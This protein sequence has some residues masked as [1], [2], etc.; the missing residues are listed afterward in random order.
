V[1]V[2]SD[3]QFNPQ[4]TV[5]A[6]LAVERPSLE[7]VGDALGNLSADFLGLFIADGAESG[8]LSPWA[9]FYLQPGLVFLA[10]TTRARLPGATSCQSGQ[11]YYLGKRYRRVSSH[12]PS[13]RPTIRT[14]EIRTSFCSTC[15]TACVC[16][17]LKLDKCLSWVRVTGTA[18]LW[19]GRDLINF[20]AMLSVLQ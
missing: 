7:I 9:T 19:I 8:E 4:I 10:V 2:L 17:L 14:H 13:L 6:N 5:R 11:E 18:F 16:E 3:R 15:F 1:D 20:V 12:D